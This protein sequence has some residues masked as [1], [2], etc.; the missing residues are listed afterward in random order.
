MFAE[1]VTAGVEFGIK[2]FFAV[3]TFGTAW[4]AVLGLFTAMASVLG[5]RKDDERE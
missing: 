3:L 4:A 1:W 5:G 2:A